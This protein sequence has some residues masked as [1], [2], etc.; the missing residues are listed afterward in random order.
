MTFEKYSDERMIELI[1]RGDFWLFINSTITLTKEDQERLEMLEIKMREKR[2]STKNVALECSLKIERDPDNWEKYWN[3]YLKISANP[4]RSFTFDG[5]EFVEKNAKPFG[6]NSAHV[7]V[8]KHWSGCR[9][10]VVRLD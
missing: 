8:P 9:V 3:E 1:E 10:A 6:D 7:G 4:I 5:F 2:K